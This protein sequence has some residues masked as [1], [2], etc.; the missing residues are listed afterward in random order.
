M[1]SSL[2]AGSAIV[3]GV[4]LSVAAL[5]AFVDAE[6]AA[7][8]T[9]VEAADATADTAASATPAADS[10]A[11]ADA[12]A[13]SSA[14]A[15]AAD[16]AAADAADADADAAD[17]AADAADAAAPAT[18][19]EVAGITVTVSANPVNVGD[20]LL[21]TLDGIEDA[22]KV[23]VGLPDAAGKQWRV[24]TVSHVE[25]GHAEVALIIPRGRV[26]E[27][28]LFIQLGHGNE[29]GRITAD[30]LDPDAVTSVPLTVVAVDPVLD[31]QPIEVP[32]VNGSSDYS[33]FS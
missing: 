3:A 7:P 9:I 10:N 1:R 4:A 26:G 16:A 18:E 15:D 8:P 14:T 2:L 29:I 17:A 30:E 13:D 19:T 12:A 25:D 33:I 11:T 5:A 28:E 23:T 27:Q 24:V 22:N 21:V 32:L 31:V 20:Q 6:E